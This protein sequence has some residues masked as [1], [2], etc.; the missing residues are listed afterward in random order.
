LSPTLER[1]LL[2]NPL[3]LE[4]V[5]NCLGDAPVAFIAIMYVIDVDGIGLVVLE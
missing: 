3:A 2:E 1:R 5:H 4:A